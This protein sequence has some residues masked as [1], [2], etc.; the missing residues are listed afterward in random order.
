MSYWDRALPYTL[1]DS[2]GWLGGLAGLVLGLLL[3]SLAGMASYRWPR[4]ENWWRASHCPSC[5]QRLSAGHLV[6]VFS[7]LV[8][9]GKSACCAT[10]ISSRYALVELACGLCLLPFGWV[11]GMGVPL[12]C[13][14]ALVW[15]LVFAS[16]VDLETGYIPDL[17]HVIVAGA[18]VLW[19]W[20]QIMGLVPQFGPWRA[21][22]MIDWLDVVLSVGQ[23]VLV[24]V[25][26][27]GLYAK[28]RGKE[29]MG[30]GDVKLMA[31]SAIWL[32]ASQ[33]P[34]YLLMAGVL[35]AVFGLI[36]RKM[37][38]GEVFPF[39]PALAVSLMLLISHK[40]FMG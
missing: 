16:T 40:V 39:G 18:G 14:A 9:R 4:D 24:G 22:S 33:V 20:M 28:L 10:P 1:I 29:M 21:F 25:L 27:A 34:I 23:A 19:L 26:L 37:G 35:G 8:M 38:K 3:G 17:T 15:A 31:A 32:P 30:W 36:W 13:M 7:W 6:P 2:T 5:G 11:L 12:L